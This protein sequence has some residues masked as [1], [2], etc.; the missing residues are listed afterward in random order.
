MYNIEDSSP[1]QR[2]GHVIITG[3]PRSGTKSVATYYQRLGLDIGHEMPGTYGTVDWRHAYH[4]LESTFRIV[5][6]AVRDPIQTVI[7]L[8][9]L[10]EAAHKYPQLPTWQYIRYLSEIGSFEDLLDDENF[11]GA[12]IQWWTSVYDH[13]Y[14]YPTI[15]VDRWQDMPH[16]NKH[17]K[18]SPA[19]VASLDDEHM[20]RFFKTARLY[21]YEY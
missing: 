14:G 5:M 17:I 7:S 12:A 16:T 13:R 20:D 10:I 6:I 3:C 19:F 9:E 4:N 18:G 8:T 15:F 1:P 21:G 11:S 2:H